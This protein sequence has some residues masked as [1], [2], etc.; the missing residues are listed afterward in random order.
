MGYFPDLR[1]KVNEA[2]A[3]LN[4][5]AASKPEITTF[6]DRFVT[7]F[8]TLDHVLPRSFKNPVSFNEAWLNAR[9]REGYH[10]GSDSPDETIE[11]MTADYPSYGGF[12]ID[13]N[14]EGA[15]LLP[16]FIFY[17]DNESE[18]QAFRAR[19][20]RGEGRANV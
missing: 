14:R 2:E 3:E 18:A 7:P 4:S 20:A 15:V 8:G 17:F 5:E 13:G 10:N 12:M 19:W 6:I 11:Q 16:E 1:S 9:L